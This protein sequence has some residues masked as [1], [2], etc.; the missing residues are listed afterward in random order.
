MSLFVFSIFVFQTGLRW[1]T[2]T[3]WE[4]YLVHFEETSSIVD[5]FL[6]ST[7][8]EQGYSY[9]VLLVKSISNNYSVFLTVHALL[10]YFLIFKAFKKLTPYLFI[11][12][13]VFYASTMG[14]MGASRQ[15]L[16]LGICLYALRFVDSRKA[17]AFFAC[18]VAAYF[19]HR[20]AVIFSVFYFLHRDIKK[21]F[22]IGILAAAV[23]L[24][25]TSFPFQ[26]FSL[27]GDYAS[28]MASSKVSLYLD[29]SAEDLAN[30]ELSVLGLVKRLLFFGLFLYNYKFLTDRIPVYKLIFNGYFVGLVFYFLFSSSLLILVNRG[31]LYF[32]AMEYFLLAFQF[33]VLTEKNIKVNF[34]IV[35]FIISIFLLFQSISSYSDLYLPY[36]GIFI[37]S[38]FNRYRID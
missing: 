24:G 1:Q 25:K 6:T 22:L 37:N 27:L 34:L 38:D 32:N 26:M 21:S 15:L 14:Y 7:G 12:L 10:Y 30:N 20:T 5:V 28:G 31:S 36:K 11:S 3:D 9:L 16:A 17:I 2:G 33:L 29:R 8:F 18:I 13:M 35:L 4:I 19:F 23:I